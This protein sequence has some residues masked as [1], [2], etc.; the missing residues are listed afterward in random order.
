MHPNARA[1]LEKARQERKETGIKIERRKADY[2]RA[3]AIN[4]M[5]KDC[6][7]DPLDKG[8]WRQQAHNCTSKDC[9]LYPYRPLS[10]KGEE[11]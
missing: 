2:T 6:N 10:T 7:Y 4:M 5:C 3:E 11:E 9:P 8:T 1:A